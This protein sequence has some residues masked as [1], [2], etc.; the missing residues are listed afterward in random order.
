MPRYLVPTY[1]TIE[2]HGDT[3]DGLFHIIVDA[4]DEQAAI[5][6]VEKECDCP[7]QCEPHNPE[8]Y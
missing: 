6:K 8:L 1:M 7:T 4:E 5:E 3:Q 2:H